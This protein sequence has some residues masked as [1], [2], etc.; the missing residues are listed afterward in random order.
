MCDI[1][2]KTFALLLYFLVNI[3]KNSTS[4]RVVPTTASRDPLTRTVEGIF[5]LSPLG[6]ASIFHQF[7]SF[8]FKFCL[9]PSPI[10]QLIFSIFQVQLSVSFARSPPQVKKQ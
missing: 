4:D 6:I 2:F 3:V 9:S 7:H 8:D 10:L 5:A 1:V